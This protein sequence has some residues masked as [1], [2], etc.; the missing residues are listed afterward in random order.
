M[1]NHSSL[2][3][4]EDRVISQFLDFIFSSGFRPKSS[5]SIIADGQIH[6][7]ALENDRSGATSGAYC[8]HMDGCP[9]GFVQDWHGKK[10]TWKYSFS[11]EE[12]REYGR[13]QSNPQQRKISEAQRAENERKKKE[14]ENS[15]MKIQQQALNMALSE[16]EAA[17]SDF[18]KHPYLVE[19]FTDKGIFVPDYGVFNT[20]YPVR[21][22]HTPI[23]GGKCRKGSLLV[24]F[25][26]IET[27]ALQTLQMIPPIRNEGGKF[28]K[29]FYG[30]L[31]Q[32]G[33]A[34]VLMPDGGE[35][36]TI[37]FCCEGFVTGLS[38]LIITGG[39]MPVYCVGGCNNYIH[40]CTAL[41]RKYPKRKICIMAD[42]DIHRKGIKAAEDCISA[43]VADDYKIPNRTGEDFY[44]VVLRK[45]G[46]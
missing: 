23:Q 19:R 20:R 34:H 29:W 10:A 7:F 24:P 17:D 15:K 16:Y 40:V 33:A 8:L 32:A 38:V 14:E 5:L 4:S 6:R 13:Q 41:R 11:D 31:P 25:V 2:G 18:H 35:N 1:Q 43:G 28:G 36:S 42:N 26:N 3:V 39:K 9:A 45:A 27:G 21:L 12:K 30:G 22:C 44:D 37:A 46:Y